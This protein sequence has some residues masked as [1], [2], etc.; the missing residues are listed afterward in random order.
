MSPILEVRDSYHLGAPKPSPLVK[1]LPS[2]DKDIKEKIKVRRSHKALLLTCIWRLSFLTHPE[3]ELFFLFHSRLPV[4]SLPLPFF[5]FLSLSLSFS[6]F[7]LFLLTYQFR[8][9]LCVVQDGLKQ[10]CSA[11]LVSGLCLLFTGFSS[12]FPWQSLLTGFAL[13]L[14]H[15]LHDQICSLSEVLLLHKGIFHYCPLPSSP[16]QVTSTLESIATPASL[17]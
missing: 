3:T 10:S 14:F 7:P 11:L 1:F 5:L 16:L 6:V 2:H 9:L 17:H 8:V 12:G 13:T 15:I 4:P